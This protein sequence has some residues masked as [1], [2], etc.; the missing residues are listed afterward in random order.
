[1]TIEALQQRLAV[2]LNTFVLRHTVDIGGGGFLR[3]RWKKCM[4]QMIMNS[5]CGEGRWEWGKGNIL[6]GKP[7]SLYMSEK[8]LRERFV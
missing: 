6:M 3:D 4:R 1:M 5:K 2:S 8:G 7:P